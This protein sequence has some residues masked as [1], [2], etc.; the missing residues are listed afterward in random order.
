[1]AVPAFGSLTVA[2]ALAPA[3]APLAMPTPVLTRSPDAWTWFTERAGTAP[4]VVDPGNYLVTKAGLVGSN[5]VASATAESPSSST[6]LGFFQ[7]KQAGTGDLSDEDVNSG[8]DALAVD[9]YFM[10][11][12][13]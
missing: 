7:V 13:N 8:P 11:Q 4:A 2:T 3:A 12:A 10:G 5:P 1:M 9:I 6:G